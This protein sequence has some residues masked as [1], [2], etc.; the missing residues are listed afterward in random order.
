MNVNE[1]IKEFIG[2]EPDRTVMEVYNIGH[3]YLLIAPHKNI[4]GP[5]FSDPQ[6]LFS[7]KTN[8][9]TP[10]IPSE[11]LKLYTKIV[12]PKNLIYSKE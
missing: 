4:A 5:D 3:L 2:K 11:D 10:F 12:N 7:A 9:Y 1:V 8:K 6:F